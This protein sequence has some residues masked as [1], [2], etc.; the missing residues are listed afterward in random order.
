ME[1]DIIRAALREIVKKEKSCD[2]GSIEN[3]HTIIRTERNGNEYKVKAIV[4]CTQCILESG[5]SELDK[6]EMGD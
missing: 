1:R 2:C 4:K 5:S 3:L 6:S